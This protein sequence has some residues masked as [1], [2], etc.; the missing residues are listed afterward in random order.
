MR[1]GRTGPGTVARLAAMPRLSLVV[2]S[3][4]LGA[5]GAIVLAACGSDDEDGTIPPQSAAAMLTA[6]D[7]ASA[8]QGEGDCDGVSDAAGNLLTAVNEAPES[9]EPDV[10]QAIVQG[11]NNLRT[12]AQDETKCRP[13]GP[14]GQEG[15]ETTTTTPPTTTEE[16]TSTT[17]TETTTTKEPPEQPPNEGNAPNPNSGG[18][19]EGQGNGP[20]GEGPPGGEVPDTGG[21]EGGG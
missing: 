11:A 18:G 20:S 14:T 21:T 13:E 2:L 19:N 7:D 15:P 17:T 1:L 3:V 12:L 8:E 16:T 5:V 4:S 10:R 9:I 6:L